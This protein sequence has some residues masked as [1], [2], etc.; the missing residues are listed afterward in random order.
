M[1]IM[2]LILSKVVFCYVW[3]Y[4]TWEHEIF[5]RRRSVTAYVRAL[6]PAGYD[7]ELENCGVTPGFMP[8]TL[9]GI[10]KLMT[11]SLLVRHSK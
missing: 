10:N 4:G 11:P 1:L 9:A 3:K 5:G 2:V 8:N 6:N 7:V